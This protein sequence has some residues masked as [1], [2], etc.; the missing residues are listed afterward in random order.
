MRNTFVTEAV[1][2]QPLILD[3][4]GG[5]VDQLRSI[6]ERGIFRSVVGII[7]TIRSTKV[8]TTLYKMIST[9]MCYNF[10]WHTVAVLKFL[11]VF[12][13]AFFMQINSW[14]GFRCA[15]GTRPWGNREGTGTFRESLSR[16]QIVYITYIL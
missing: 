13:F 7:I 12:G 4:R 11:F 8:K 14:R 10:F 2:S 5:K 16:I 3:L 15:R 1:V 9:V 6:L